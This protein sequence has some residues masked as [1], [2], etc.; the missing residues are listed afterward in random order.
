VLYVYN[1]LIH[2][3]VNRQKRFMKN[4]INRSEVVD[5]YVELII[6]TGSTYFLTRI[7]TFEIWRV[8]GGL[9]ALAHISS[10]SSSSVL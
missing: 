5:I 10:T 8:E 7:R 1:T 3:N 2:I 6:F 9:T 4:G